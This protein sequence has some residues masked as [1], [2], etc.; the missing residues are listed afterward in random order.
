MKELK[1][2][3]LEDIIAGI[4]ISPRSY[5]FYS[6]IFRGKNNPEKSHTNAHS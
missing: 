1:P 4:S 3:S 2:D 5:G 6:E